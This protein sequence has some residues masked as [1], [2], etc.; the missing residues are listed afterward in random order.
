[1]NLNLFELDKIQQENFGM[2][3]YTNEHRGNFQEAAKSLSYYKSITIDHPII[4]EEIRKLKADC[5]ST[6][7]GKSKL[8]WSDFRKI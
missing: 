2:R 7:H 6:A 4:V 1:M 5:T 3:L 8:T